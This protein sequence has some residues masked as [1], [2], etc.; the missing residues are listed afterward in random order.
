MEERK[1]AKKALTAKN[2]GVLMM[3]VLF[4]HG[5]FHIASAFKALFKSLGNFL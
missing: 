3:S 5:W 4:R 2:R 1:N